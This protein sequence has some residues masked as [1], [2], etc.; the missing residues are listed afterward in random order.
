MLRLG[1][2]AFAVSS[3]TLELFHLYAEEAGWVLDIKCDGERVAL[4]GRVR[5]P[6]LPGPSLLVASYVDAPR[7]FT[8][9][10]SHGTLAAD[11]PAVTCVAKGAGVVRISGEVALAWTPLLGGEPRTVALVID[12]DVALIT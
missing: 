6:A 8:L 12:L 9:N 1:D 4:E 7:V 2:R 3:A 10:G 11:R 5:T